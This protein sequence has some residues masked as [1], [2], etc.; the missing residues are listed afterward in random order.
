[1][2]QNNKKCEK[3]YFIDSGITENA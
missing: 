2:Q 3:N 1:M